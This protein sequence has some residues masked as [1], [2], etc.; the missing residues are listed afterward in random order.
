MRKR[1]WFINAAISFDGKISEKNKKVELS[2]KEDWQVVH[3]LRNISAAI[4][5]GS[6]TILIDNPKLL[7]KKEFFPNGTQ[8]NYPVRIILDRRGRCKTNAMV[9]QNQDLASTIW[10][11]NSNAN[12]KGIT[13]ISGESIHDIVSE[14]NKY[15]DKINRQGNVMIE[16]GSKVITS[17]IKSKL[18][19]KIRLYRSPK[20]LVDGLP[21]FGDNIENPLIL[22]K[23]RKLGVGM[24]EIYEI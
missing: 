22:K 3:Q 23:V 21:L 14:V 7:T 4:V 5:V 17:F 1:S 15:L 9:F 19:D 16:G 12:V 2:S 24:E 13:K 10:V 18:V 11:T 6:N 20:V 8:I